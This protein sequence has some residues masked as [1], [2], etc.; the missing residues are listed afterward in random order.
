[1]VELRVCRANRI[2]GEI[3]V[4]GDKSISHRAVM[5]ASVSEG[6]T[7]LE[8]FSPGK[9]CLS[10]VRCFKQMGVHIEDS[11]PGKVRIHGAG[12][13]GLKEPENILDAGN[14]GTTM[15]LLL[16]ILAGQPFFSV[17][18]GDD[19]LRQ[20]PMDRVITPLRLMGA[21]IWGRKQGSRAPVAVS[22]SGKLQPIKYSSPIPSAQVKSAVLL[23]GLFAEGQTT[24]SEPVLSRDH[25]ERMLDW[26]GADVQRYDDGRTVSIKGR[27]VLR[28]GQ[29]KIPG[30]ISSA[31]FFIAAGCLLPGSEM[32]IANVG[33][34]PTRSGII[35]TFKEMGA[36]ITLLNKREECGEPVADVLV[37]QAPLHSVEISGRHLP[38]LIDEI[39]ILAVAATQ[40]EGTTVIRDAAELRFKETDRIKAIAL[41]LGRMGAAIKET[42]DGLIIEGPVPLKG[43]VC[44]SHGDH[45]IAMS[46]AIA[47]LVAEGE[48][49]IQDSGIIEISFPG[50]REKLEQF[51]S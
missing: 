6:I 35:R 38:S 14:S 50:F 1:M 34:N 41:E 3:T 43:T 39:P 31:A 5:L 13:Y 40:A 20:R 2:S 21:E 9:D 33:I 15:R 46:L 37:R 28:A 10:T 4:P 30:D 42:P 48:T 32:L 23:C 36:D 25:T 51:L 7:Q 24:V 22:A 45:R 11:G 16:G 19:S 8:G 44:L 29:I 49:I 47:G 12:L 18:T 26:F 27:P 17:V